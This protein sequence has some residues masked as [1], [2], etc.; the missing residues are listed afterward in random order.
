MEKSLYSLWTVFPS[1]FLWQL[2]QT[3]LT[4]SKC[5]ASCMNHSESYSEQDL[6]IEKILLIKE[7]FSYHCT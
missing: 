2:F 4:I 5:S 7:E 6:T 1:C 3:Y